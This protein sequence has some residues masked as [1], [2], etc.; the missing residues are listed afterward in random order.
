MKLL[1]TGGTGF[2]GSYLLA[3]LLQAGHQVVAVRR[4]GS[5]PVISLEKEPLWIERSFLELS[6]SDL[7]GVEAIIHLASA[8]VSPQKASWEDLEKINIAASLRLIQLSHEAGVRR[9]I[10]AG[11]CHEYGLEADNWERISPA[12]P[13]KPITP[14]GSSKAASFL[15]LQAFAIANQME[16]FYGR[17]FSAY[18]EG[19]F[20]GNLWPS[21][22]QAALQGADFPMTDGGQL[23]DFIPVQAVAKN[24]ATAICR[25][26]IVA[27]NPFVVNI[28]SGQGISVLEFAKRCWSELGGSG[29]LKPGALPNRPHQLARMVADTSG[30]HYLKNLE[31]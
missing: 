25:K 12:A 14:Y 27:G 11:T 2:I 31:A 17:I 3:E 10:A 26:D 19:Q 28:G 8:G 29:A 20:A 6:T 23:V 5:E 9:F 21:L 13:L 16:F 15:M 7:T 18:G 24:L 30:L 1:I 4:V 22:R